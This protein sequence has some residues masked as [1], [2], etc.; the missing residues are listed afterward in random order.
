[1]ARI[2]ENAKAVAALVGTIATALLAVFTADTKVGQVLT[3]LSVAATA[4]ATWRIPN[5]G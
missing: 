5:A 1:M 2:L 3:V 4:F